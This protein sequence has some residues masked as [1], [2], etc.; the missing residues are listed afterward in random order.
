MDRLWQLDF[1]RRVA[2][3]RL[4]EIIGSETLAIDKYTRLIGINRMTDKYL[5][6]VS[7]ADLLV[8]ENY[9][10]G[11]NK[12]VE[13]VQAYPIEFY[14]FWTEFEPFTPRDSVAI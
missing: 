10:A 12:V 2:Q 4:S 1:M 3:G 13:Q 7:S 9:A 5:A 14:V 6:E 8:L 11:I